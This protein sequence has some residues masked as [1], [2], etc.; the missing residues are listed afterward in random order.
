MLPD[1]PTSINPTSHSCRFVWDQVIGVNIALDCNEERIV[2]SP[3]FERLRH[4]KQNGFAYVEY[5]NARHSRYEHSL[6]TVYWAELMYR[7]LT[8]ESGF[9]KQ[10]LKALRMAALI[11][12]VGHGPFSHTMELLLKRNPSWQ[13]SIPSF[14]LESGRIKENKTERLQKHELLTKEFAAVELNRLGIEKSLVYRVFRI[15]QGN[16]K[17]LSLIISGD[18]DADR[19]D[20][21]ARDAYYV[22]VSFGRETGNMFKQ[23][24]EE[25]IRYQDKGGRTWLT[26]KSEGVRALE[27]FLISRF[28][29]YT[30]IYLN[31]RVRIADCIFV[32]SLEK[33]LEK[34]FDSDAERRRVILSIF[35]F[36]DDASLL[37]LDLSEN[38]HIEHISELRKLAESNNLRQSFKKLARGNIEEKKW[39]KR[40]F[41]SF[42]V[43]D[44][45][46]FF[47]IHE[48]GRIRDIEL[49]AA[50]G[51]AHPLF[52]D[53]NIP[54]A[55]SIE[56]CVDDEEISRAYGPSFLFDYS[57]L[58]RGLEQAMYH[59]S[60][61]ISN[62]EI[63]DNMVHRLN[64]AASRK[65]RETKLDITAYAVIQ[66]LRLLRDL[67]GREGRIRSSIE[68]RLG[69]LGHRANLIRLVQKVDMKLKGKLRHPLNYAFLPNKMPYYSKEVYEKTRVLSFLNVITEVYDPGIVKDGFIPAFLYDLGPEVAKVEPKIRISKKERK[70]INKVFD[71]IFNES[72]GE[73]REAAMRVSS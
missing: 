24:I 6:G 52:I 71:D 9:K 11:H 57:P 33:A 31:P 17:K 21:L 56:T 59:S 62:E 49:E 60:A 1:D 38:D 14:I 70:V 10:A 26:V 73:S 48:S 46:N 36:L 58:V 66:S 37:S 15:L 63:T 16:E 28:A 29:S 32:Q 19:L 8:R 27:A 44:L 42:E 3:R 23:M 5:P 72:L 69:L 61:I 35:R 41:A 30:N 65:L 51:Y 43:D 53:I 22:G 64:S 12:D 7:A 34:Q 13:P 39:Q 67:R 68:S 18:L 40:K 4:I 2:E 54:W 45:Y 25:N 50:K 20:Y 47:R 55:L